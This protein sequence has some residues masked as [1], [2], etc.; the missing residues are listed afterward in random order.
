[1]MK[2]GEKDMMFGDYMTQAP[3]YHT[4]LTCVLL[5]LA[6]HQVFCIPLMKFFA[7]MMSVSKEKLVVK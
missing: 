3:V 4:A 2:D 5:I 1:M 6:M 7:T